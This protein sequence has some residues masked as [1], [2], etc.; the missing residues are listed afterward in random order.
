VG[1]ERQSDGTGPGQP[2]DGTGDRS[3]EPTISRRRLGGLAL[4]AG[5]LAATGLGVEAA[6]ASAAGERPFAATGHRPDRQPNV[7][8]ILADDLGWADLSCYGAI[9]TGTPEL[10]RL[11]RDG[12]RFTNAYSGSAVCSPTRFSLYTGRY[13]GRLPGGLAEPIASAS[14][15][16]GIPPEH[17]TLASLLRDA[18]YETALVGKWHC[19]FLPWF[20]PLKSGWD[21]FF[22][23]LSGAV[24][25][26]HHT[27]GQGN[28]DLYEGEVAVEEIGYYTDL[29]AERAVDFVRRPH[30]RPWLLNL[31]FTTPH[32]PWEGPGD[33]AESD[34]LVS[35]RLSLFH[36]DGG[37]LATFA[38]MVTSL[39]QAVGRVLRALSRS[40]QERD[41]LVVFGSDNGGERF[42]YQW[43]LRGAKG[44]LYEGGIRIPQVVRWPGHIARRQVSD[45]P[46]FPPDWTATLIDLAGAEPHPDYPLDGVSL[47]PYL[48]DGERPP[49][50][51]LFWRMRGQA[52]LRRGDW[53]YVSTV[54]HD[55]G[56]DG[57]TDQLYDLASD[58]SEQANLASRAPA[59]L[60]ELK[61]AWQAIADELLPYPSPS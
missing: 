60:A 7:L 61:A 16:S 11:A 24:D 41:T 10:D 1:V 39:D 50:R 8:F 35:N 34:R 2:E 15:Q 14:P 5:A 56:A 9:D 40:G 13:P 38:E 52:A 21:E 6:P 31:N 32:W 26:F 4:G 23:N 22:G 33:Q 57:P 58:P 47:V 17:P 28:P 36:Y 29:I 54:D 49:E 48:L 42:S 18:G 37:S 51:D 44:Q 25:Y 20:S 55:D 53:K 3:N 30:D 19:G 59:R 27:D 43:P 45:V 46:V 12:L